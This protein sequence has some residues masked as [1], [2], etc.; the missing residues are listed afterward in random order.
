MPKENQAPP[1]PPVTSADPP[2]EQADGKFTPLELARATGHMRQLTQEQ[3]VRFGGG[4][5]DLKTELLSW[6][7]TAA[8][9][10]HGWNAHEHHAGGSFRMTPDDYAGA[11][12]AAAEHVTRS[13]ESIDK[14]TGKET[15]SEPLT[16]KQ[17]ADLNGRK[18]TR[19]DYE[20]HKPAMSPH[21]HG[22]TTAA[23]G[24]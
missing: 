12:K 20:P 1:A 13:V 9:Q 21:A 2:K 3:A 6:E 19:S 18:P 24:S 10:L 11:L 23:K 4:N 8:A 7:H 17:V 22:A 15:L 16:P 5:A 14:A